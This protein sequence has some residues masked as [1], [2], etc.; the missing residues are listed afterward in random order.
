LENLKAPSLA[1]AK[2]IAAECADKLSASGAIYAAIRRAG[3]VHNA[4][5]QI[6]LQQDA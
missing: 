6:D 4:L 1:D 3:M 2:E 5:K